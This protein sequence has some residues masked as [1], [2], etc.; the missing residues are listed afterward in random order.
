MC[1][2]SYANWS[3]T[4]IVATDLSNYRND[5]IWRKNLLVNGTFI[6][7]IIFAKKEKKLH[8]VSF[9][10]E[11]YYRLTLEDICKR[12]KKRRKRN[13]L[14]IELKI[15]RKKKYAIVYSSINREKKKYWF[16]FERGSCQWLET[17]LWLIGSFGR[18]AWWDHSC[19]DQ[20][21]KRHRPATVIYI[22]IFLVRL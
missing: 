7:S 4:P 12:R 9:W 6:I 14:W 5:F 15:V 2:V 13:F 8:Y 11:F 10:K 1:F 21:R 18:R 22:Y 20:P 16:H 3:A 17:G 19:Y